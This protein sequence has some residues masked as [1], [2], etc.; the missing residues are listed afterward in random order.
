M[1]ES[2]MCIICQSAKKVLKGSNTPN[3]D[4][5]FLHQGYAE[6]YRPRASKKVPEIKVTCRNFSHIRS[7]KT[8]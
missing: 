4:S 2:R 6:M 7:M 1:N 3:E 5:C 8:R